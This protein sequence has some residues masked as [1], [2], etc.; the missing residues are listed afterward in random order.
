MIDWLR[1]AW[2]WWLHR[3]NDGDLY[4]HLVEVAAEQARGP[5]RCYDQQRRGDK[6]C[7]GTPPGGHTSWVDVYDGPSG[8]GYVVNYERVFRGE[9]YRRRVNFGPE[10]YHDEPWQPRVPWL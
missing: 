1:G 8:V 10:T 3:P 7:G 4:K 5:G 2:R 6:C 9:T